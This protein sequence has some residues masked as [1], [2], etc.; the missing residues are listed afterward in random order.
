MEKLLW[1]DV[2]HHTHNIVLKYIPLFKYL[3]YEYWDLFAE[4]FIKFLECKEFYPNKE[5][6]EFV[7][8]YFTAIKN[9]FRNILKK[10]YTF[11]RNVDFILDDNINNILSSSEDKDFLD[12][13]L[14]LEYSPKLIKR[15]I[16]V[17]NEFY[18]KEENLGKKITNTYLCNKLNPG[19]H[20]TVNLKNYFID[21]VKSK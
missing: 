5:K 6:I 3:G 10:E 4:C 20:R 14:S 18:K 11:L 19:T 17:I 16:D 7:N 13:K 21:Y 9:R 1:K 15:I 2:E 12:L 8:I